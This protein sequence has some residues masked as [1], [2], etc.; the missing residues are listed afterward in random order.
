[1]HAAGSQ[2]PLDFGG[3][4]SATVLQ[5]VR[6]ERRE[7]TVRLVEYAPFPRVRR[8]QRWRVGFTR[9]LSPGGACLRAEEV[10]PVGSL[11]H[12]IVRSVDGRPTL[13]SIA[14]VV[15]CQPGDSGEVRLGLA[16]VAA[17]PR[18]VHRARRAK[19]KEAAQAA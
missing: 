11:L 8:D 12:V 7:A 6:K 10:A 13:D 5:P 19:G 14:R 16:L 18:R 2:L 17:R 15:W 3:S 1:M 4:G 9:D